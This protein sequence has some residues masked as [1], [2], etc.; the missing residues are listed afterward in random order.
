VRY[1]HD[2]EP[3]KL[4]LGPALVLGDG[5]AEPEAPKIGQPLTLAAARRL[6][7]EALH[8]HEQ[9]IDPAAEKKRA[10]AAAD[11]AAADLGRDTVEK[12]AA[13]FIE[14][15]AKKKNRSWKA[16]EWIFTKRVLPQWAGRTVHDIKRRDIIELVEGIAKDTPILANRVLAAVRKWFRWMAGRD[17][18][19]TSPCVDVQPPGKENA[20]DRVLSDDEIK[21]LWKGSGEVGAPFGPF[22]KLLLL[23][24]QRRSEVAGMRW[25]E[26]DKD[27]GEWKLPQ[28]RTKNASAHTVPLSR[29][30]WAII[31]AVEPIAGSNDFV[32]TTTG[33]SG[34][35]GFSRAKTR[36]DQ[37]QRRGRSTICGAPPQAGCRGSAFRS[38]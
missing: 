12:L 1:R 17:I 18:I 11:K 4:T 25:A 14:R 13:D 21:A 27:K 15:H 6:A 29:Q 34:L 3:R 32:L 23:T 9:G 36:L 2:G 7:G 19:T 8:K 38:R 26:I 37:T 30:A 24:G 35:G 33:N 5:E 10:K 28:E 31:K 16:T 22:V 20:R